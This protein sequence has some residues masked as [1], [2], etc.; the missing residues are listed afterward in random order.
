MA[1]FFSL[2]ADKVICFEAENLE[3]TKKH[4]R[5]QQQQNHTYSTSQM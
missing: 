1:L 5:K 3:N 2:P 4:K